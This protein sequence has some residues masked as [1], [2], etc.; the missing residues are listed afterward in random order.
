MVE[1]GIVSDGSETPVGAVEAITEDDVSLPAPVVKVEDLVIDYGS[2][3][4]VNG[5]SFEVAPG[6]VLGL[7]GR[8]G[9]GKSSTLRVL[10]TVAPATEGL[11]EVAGFDL[12]RERDAEKARQV[13]GYCPDVG[14]VIRSATIREHI[15]LNLALHNRTHLWNQALEL[16]DRFALTH[17]LDKTAAGFSHGMTRRLSVI[18]AALSS[19]QLL[20][21]DEPFDGVDPVGVETTLELVREAKA[22][23]LSVILSTHLQDV[24]AAGTD[25]IL[26]AVDG[27]IVDGGIASEFAGEEGKERYVAALGGT[28]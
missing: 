12:S 23:G 3:R 15:G 22:S 14:G 28:S 5:I 24:L 1:E 9:A 10:S 26:V 13:I 27:R 6:E 25:R 16:V 18:L 8:N 21:L 2:V 7:L 4:A 20:I 11:V 19:E 17:A